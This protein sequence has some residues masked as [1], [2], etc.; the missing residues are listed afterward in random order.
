MRVSG[1]SGV[2]SWS[3]GRSL[4]SPCGG[5]VVGIRLGSFMPYTHWSVRGPVRPRAGLTLPQRPHGA[6]GAHPGGPSRNESV[7]GCET[8]RGSRPFLRDADVLTVR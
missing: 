8:I 1:G 4:L 2:D 3:P 5:S 7:N 6:V